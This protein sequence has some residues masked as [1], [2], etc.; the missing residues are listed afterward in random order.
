MFAF[1]DTYALRGADKIAGFRRLY[2]F[3]GGYDETMRDRAARTKKGAHTA[4]VVYVA[5]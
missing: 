4:P 1:L 5:M 2:Y 3:V